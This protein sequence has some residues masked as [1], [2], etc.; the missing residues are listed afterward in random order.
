[1]WC[2][3]AMAAHDARRAL[4]PALA[5]IIGIAGAIALGTWQ[6]GR[7]A[8]KRELSARFQ[9]AAGQPPVHV[10]RAELAA[11]DVE[12]RRIEA[13]GV[14]EP[15]HAVYID[16][17][18]RR[19]V[20]GFHVVMPL[21]IEGGDTYV[22]VNRGW[23][24]APARRGELPQVRTPREQVAVTGIAVI[25][26]RRVLELSSAVIEGQ[27]WQNLTIERY[28]RAMPLRVQPFVLRQ[29]SALDDGLVREWDAPDFGIDKHYGYAFQWFALAF[30]LF[31]FYVVTQFKRRRPRAS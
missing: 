7:G 13:R 19:G 30:A 12:L 21:R 18:I 25:P 11:N 17:R 3:P 10:G 16:N 31:V 4:W 15:R 22:L 2:L 23:I 20:P 29:D 24:A 6:L 26:G 28:R 5:A 27:I 1:M 9:A 8:E 14:F